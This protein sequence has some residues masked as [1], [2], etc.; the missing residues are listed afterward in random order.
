[1]DNKVTDIYLPRELSVMLITAVHTPPDADTKAALSILY[2]SINDQ[3]TLH[4]DGVFIVAGDINQVD[5]K[6][7][8]P[9][10]YQHVG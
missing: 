1:M 4:P 5:M 10:F 7:V 9:H 6:K 8:S 3:Q 2:S